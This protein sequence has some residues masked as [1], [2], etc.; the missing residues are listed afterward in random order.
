MQ[1]SWCKP[2]GVD[3]NE[4][5]LGQPLLQFLQDKVIT[6]IQLLLQ[7]FSL[8]SSS[9]LSVMA[10]S[11]VPFLTHDD[12][13]DDDKAESDLELTE[14]ELGATRKRRCHRRKWRR[15]HTTGHVII[16]L[17][18]SWGFV[19]LC[20][21]IAQRITAQSWLFTFSAP[22]PYH[23]ETLEPG[24]NTCHCGN[25]IKEALERGCV[26]DTMATAWLPPYCRD[27]ELTAEFDRSGPGPGGQWSYF[28]DKAGNVPLDRTEMA[29]L[30]ETKGSFWASRDWHI[31]HCLFYW[32]KFV[33]IRNTGVV[34]EERFDNLDHVKHCS[35]LIRNPVP[36]HFFLIEVPVRMNSSMDED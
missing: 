36:D 6:M 3:S 30:G 7:P 34:M 35:R 8:L 22:D 10:S 9:Q 33:R 5:H 20:L 12:D 4:C 25:T 17:L 29:R 28:A 27:E 15:L 11:N 14:E 2:H 23:P 26:Y 16:L 21:A 32:Q 13:D 19:S 24:R 31:V 18:A 1:E